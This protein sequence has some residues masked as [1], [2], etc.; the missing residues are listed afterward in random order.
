MSATAIELDRVVRRYRDHVAVD[1]VDLAVERGEFF[2]LLGPSGCGKSTTL[3]LIAGLERPDAGFVHQ[4]GVDVTG[5]PPE[6]RNVSTVFQD[7]AVFPHMTVHQNVSFPLR[8]RHTPRAT[9]EREVGLVL[10]RVGLTGHAHRQPS[11]LSGGQRQRVALARSLVWHPGALLLDEPLAALDR[12]LRV[13]MQAFLKDLQRD[14]GITFVYVTHD[15]GEAMG[16]SDRIA[17]VRDGRVVQVGTPD[18]IYRRPNSMFVASFVGS[19]NV[20]HGRLRR[21][22]RVPAVDVGGRLMEG[23]AT[24]SLGAGAR[25]GSDVTI[26][27]RPE[28]VLLD[29]PRDRDDIVALD[30]RVARVEHQGPVLDVV[31]ATDLGEIHAVCLDRDV[32]GAPRPATTLVIGWSSRHALVFAGTGDRG[33]FQPGTPVAA[34]GPDASS[35]DHPSRYNGA[36]GTRT[37][38]LV[39]PERP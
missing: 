17:V 16:L 38:R 26:A 7:Y 8:M 37:A 3:R 22:G 21:T 32:S 2:T 13:S 10:E 12:N 9:I 20:L 30:A 36:A 5:V 18:E 28:C 1:G 29:P 35:D 15:Q 23:Q 4:D 25:E 19:M 31:L 33:E 39:P 11:E 24:P 27:F 14:L 6:R 34:F